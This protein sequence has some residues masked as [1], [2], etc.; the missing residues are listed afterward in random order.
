MSP[1]ACF[2]SAVSAVLA[3]LHVM[4]FGLLGVCVYGMLMC[5]SVWFSVTVTHAY[6]TALFSPAQSDGYY[7]ECDPGWTGPNCENDINECHSNPCRNAGTCVDTINGF[8]CEC[9][10]GFTGRE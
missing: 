6:V 8:Y 2:A 4:N 9:A 5:V 10:S 7:C 3:M 1:L